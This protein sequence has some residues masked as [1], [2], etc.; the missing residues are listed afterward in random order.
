MTTTATTTGLT[1]EVVRDRDGFR[2]LEHQWRGLYE[3]CPTATPFQTWE[4]LYTWWEVYGTRGA[5]RVVTAR[6]GDRLVGALPLMSTGRGRLQFVGTGLSDHLDLLT[7][8]AHTDDVLDAWI[9]HLHRP[10]VRLLDLHEVRPS[11]QAWQLY[12]RWPGRSGRYEQSTC[13][14]FD[15][16]PLDDLLASWKRNVRKNARLAINRVQKGG[17]TEHWA[18]PEDAGDMAEA[19]V[20]AHQ[21]MWDERS[22]TPAHA[23]PRFVRFVRTVCERLAPHGQVGLV[24]LDAPEGLDDPMSLHN[25]MFIGREYIGGWLS[26]YNE[27]ARTRMTVAVY[28]DIQGIRLANR[29]G[30]GVMSMLRGL[31]DGKLKTAERMLVNHRLLLAGPGPR[32]GLAWATQAAPTAAVAALKRWEK[33]GGTGQRVTAALRSARERVRS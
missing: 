32:A 24:R 13:A 31:E 21:R 8:P 28:E 23:E 19:L 16:A 25:L 20:L 17:Y 5:L 7:D 30:I 2:S 1:I 15:I 10:G 4:W 3:A 12:G 14:E 26:G 29:E 18:T 9:A 27:A 6:A 22:I 11:A 33:D